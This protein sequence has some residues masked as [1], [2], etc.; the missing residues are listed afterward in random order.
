MKTLLNPNDWLAQHPKVM[1]A[2]AAALIVIVGLLE[3]APC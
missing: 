2:I 1:L 3:D